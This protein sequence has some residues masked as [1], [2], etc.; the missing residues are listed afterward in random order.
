MVLNCWEVDAKRRLCFR[1]IVAELS[2]LIDFNDGCRV[3]GN[4]KM[5]L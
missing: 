4:K 5:L 1:G 3:L 2:K